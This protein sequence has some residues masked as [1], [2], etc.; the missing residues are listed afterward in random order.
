MLGVGVL[1]L[2][3]YYAFPL[4]ILP[5]VGATLL[6][7]TFKAARVPSL[8]FWQSWKAFLATV[9]YGFLGMILLNCILPWKGPASGRLVVLL[10]AAWAIQVIALPLL[11]RKF[12]ARALVAQEV[13][14]LVTNLLSVAVLVWLVQ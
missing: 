11:L 2:A 4:L 14:I 12:T 9:A 6:G 3:L 5:L 10:L 8:S 13:T 1:L 7:W